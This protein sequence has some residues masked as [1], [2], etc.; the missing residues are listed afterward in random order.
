MRRSIL[1]LT[2]SLFWSCHSDQRDDKVNSKDTSPKDPTISDSINA[3]DSDQLTENRRWFDPRTLDTT[4]TFS[5]SIHLS[6]SYTDTTFTNCYFLECHVID[7]ITNVHN[8]RHLEA[9]DIEKF[10][11]QKF[12]DHVKR[13]SSGLYVKLENEIWKHLPLSRNADEVDNIFEY[14]FKDFGFY[15]IRVQWGEGNAFK[16][17]ND[18]NGA[19]T[20]LYG[21]PYFSPNG[22]YVISVSADIDAGYN[23]NGFQLLENKNGSLI[24]LGNHNPNAWGPYSAKWTSNN[25]IILKNRTMDFANQSFEYIDF[26]SEIKIENGG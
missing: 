20:Q 2:I 13:D 25:R 15:L 10:Q 17:V 8:N 19:E 22:R 16:L 12:G 1:I 4:F 24:H 26:C 7:S 11:L 18:A 21:R 5:D 23:P 3:S 14:Y 6:L 9:L